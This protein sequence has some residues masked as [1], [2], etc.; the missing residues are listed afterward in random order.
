MHFRLLCRLVQIPTTVSPRTPQMMLQR[1][2][3]MRVDRAMDNDTPTNNHSLYLV[4]GVLRE[5]IEIEKPGLVMA[6]EGAFRECHFYFGTLIS[7]FQMFNFALKT[8]FDS[9]VSHC[10]NKHS[11]ATNLLFLCELPGLDTNLTR[12]ESHLEKEDTALRSSLTMNS[13]RTVKSTPRPG[14][15]L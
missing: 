6:G 9:C 10:M 14:H 5:P 7:S 8:H 12:S 1:K 11:P 15:Y 4:L 13:C 2:T 3:T